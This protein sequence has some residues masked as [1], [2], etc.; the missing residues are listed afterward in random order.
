MTS[1]GFEAAQIV[2]R[3]DEGYESSDGVQI[4]IEI[5]ETTT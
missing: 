4:G 5:N 2:E 1:G 3:E